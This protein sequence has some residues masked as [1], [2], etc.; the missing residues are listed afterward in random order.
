MGKKSVTF[1][2]LFLLCSCLALAHG[3]KTLWQKYDWYIIGAG[4]VLLGYVLFRSA[5]K[6]V[7]LVLL[8]AVGMVIGRMLLDTGTSEVGVVGDLHYHADFALYVN[9][10]R[11]DFAREKYL[12][13]ENESLSNFAHL[14]DLDGNVIHKH[15][16]G[17]TLGFFLETLG[18]KLDDTCLV[19]DEGTSYCNEGNKELKMYV[20]GKHNDK[21]DRYDLQDEDRILLSYGDEVEQEINEQIQSVTDEACIYSLK[22]PEKGTPPEEATCIG[23]TCTVEG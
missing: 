17:V 9:G 1:S 12:S 13:T 19:L 20:D 14:H 6:L 3:E 2:I 8:I 23:E 22:C 18:M 16:E 7:I 10:E 5:K 4:L 15:A 21:F 11:Y